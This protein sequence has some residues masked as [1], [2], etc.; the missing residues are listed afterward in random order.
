[1]GTGILSI[2]LP[3]AVVIAAPF[4]RNVFDMRREKNYR[5]MVGSVFWG[6]VPFGVICVIWAASGDSPVRAQNMVLGLVGAAIGASGMIWV[7]YFVRDMSSKTDPPGPSSSGPASTQMG[8]VNN[9]GIVTQGQFGNN[10]IINPASPNYSGTLT[11]KATLL[12]SPNKDEASYIPKLQFGTSNVIYGAK[13]IGLESPY[14]S[15]LFPALSERQFK[16]ESIDGKIKV[17]TQ[18]TDENGRLI[19]ELIRNEWK[20]AP[21]PS[22]WD[23]NYSDD[24]LEVRDAFGNVVL[25]IKV[26]PDR[27]QL[28]G[29]WWIDLG[30]PNGAVR[31]FIRGNP[32]DGGQ[33]VIVPKQN[34]TPPPFI[35]P[36]FRYPSDQ[37]LGKL[38]ARS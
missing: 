4:F 17:S 25:Q 18:I 19:A 36:M 26:L 38:A 37:N 24:A 13:E 23:R 27:I 33:V 10:T 35:D 5:E 28:Q 11:P 2:A 15:L 29:V 9:E 20:V 31:L 1:M 16:I 6:V 30:P 21:P 7:G 32:K 3:I 34:K 12:F 22:A 8:A 14:G